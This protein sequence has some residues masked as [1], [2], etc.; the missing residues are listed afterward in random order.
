MDRIDIYEPTVTPLPTDKFNAKDDATRLRD[1]IKEKGNKEEEFIRLF[2]NRSAMQRRKIVDAY[3][4]EFARDLISDLK[5]E[6]S[7]KFEDL[8]LALMD[9]TPE[10]LAKELNKAMVK[11]GTDEH[12]LTEI[13]CTRRNF[14]TKE[15]AIKY[16][17]LFGISLEDHLKKEVSGEYFRLLTLLLWGSRQETEVFPDKAAEMAQQLYDAC[18]GKRGV[19]EEVFVQILA[20]QSIP[21]LKLVFESYKVISG[22]TFE[23]VVDS[24]FSIFQPFLKDAILTIAKWV[25][26][27]KVGYYAEKLEKALKGVK[28]HRTIVRIIVSRSEV[29]LGAIKRAYEQRFSKTLHS[30]VAKE[31]SGHYETALIRLLGES[32]I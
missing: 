31:T 4:M 17:E 28:D 19:D 9:P 10:F 32:M 22:K 15:I 1:V 3:K 29:D 14:E 25:K 16:L 27:D 11:L 26:G 18:E 21:Q 5:S 20:H 30:Q 8:I 23:Q 2:S 6:T 12:V 24:E 13:L 7:G